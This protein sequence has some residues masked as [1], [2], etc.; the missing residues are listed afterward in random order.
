MPIFLFKHDLSQ[1]SNIS[2]LFQDIVTEKI[3][4]CLNYKLLSK[5]AIIQSYCDTEIFA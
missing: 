3:S 4:C 1:I 2:E 5:T